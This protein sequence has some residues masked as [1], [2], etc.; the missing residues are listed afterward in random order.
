MKTSGRKDTEHA[1]KRLNCISKHS[2]SIRWWI[3]HWRRQMP[4][5]NYQ[6]VTTLDKCDEIFSKQIRERDGWRCVRCRRSFAHSPWLLH[7]SHFFGRSNKATRYSF[8]NCDAVCWQCHPIW[9]ADKNGDYKLFKIEQ[10]GREAYEALERR[11][12]S[13]IRFGTW[14]QAQKL[15]ELKHGTIV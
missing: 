4:R 7:N 15:K 11:A 10:L 8:D 1:G 3:T 13:I 9:E 14:E 6:Q 5:Y 2:S 12:R